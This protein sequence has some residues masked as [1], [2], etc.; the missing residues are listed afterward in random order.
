MH[1]KSA[2]YYSTQ[3]GGFMRYLLFE[4]ICKRAEYDAVKIDAMARKRGYTRTIPL[5]D[6]REAIHEEMRGEISVINLRCN[7]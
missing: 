2:C 6:L 4:A 1:L 5:Q 7:L 3:R